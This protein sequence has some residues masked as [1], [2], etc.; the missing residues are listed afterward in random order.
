MP[1]SSILGKAWT[2]DQVRKIN[3]RFK[4]NNVLD[5]GVG[6]GTYIDNYKSIVSD[7]IWTGI[8]VWEPYIKQYDLK[9][10]YN[11]II[12]QDVRKVDYNNLGKFDIVFAG[13][14]LEHMTK[15]EAIVVVDNLLKIS[16]SLFISIPIVHMPQGEWAGNPYEE[17][18]KDDWSDDEVKQTFGQYIVTSGSFEEI[19]VYLLS[20]DNEF[21]QQFGNTTRIP[22]IIHFIY[23]GYTDF[24][25][26]H[27]AS[28]KSAITVHKPKKVYIYNSIEPTNNKYWNDIVKHV[29]VVKVT[30]PEEFNNI[31]LEKFQYKADIFRLQKLIEMGGIYMDIDVIS[32]K[33]F[34]DLLHESLVLGVESADNPN[35]IDLN[36]IKSI[37]NAVILAE[38]NHPFL[39]EWLKQTG[40]NLE[41]K[42]WAYHAVNL[43]LELTKQQDWHYQLLPRKSFMPFDFRDEFIF[44]NDKNQLEKINDSYTMHLWETIWWDKLNNIDNNSLLH[45]IIKP[46][47][48]KKLKIAIYTICKNEEEFV[49]RWAK[50]NTEADIRLVCDTGSTDNTVKK[51]KKHKVNVVP[52][53]VSPWRFDT[54]RNTALNLLPADIDVCIWQDL[55]EELLPGWRQAIESNWQNN[56]TTANHRYR[57]NDGNWQWHNKIHA[58]HGCIW[59]GAVHESLKW[60]V[61][62]SDIWIE[63]FYLDEHQNT[64]KPRSSYLPLLL[65][66]IEEGDT[67]WRTFF[68]LSNEYGA[69]FEKNLENKLKAYE[70]CNEGD[71]VK[72]YIARA[73]GN[74]Y[75]HHN[76]NDLAKTWYELSLG[77]SKERETYYSLAKFYNTIQDHTMCFINAE[78]G[79]RVT[80]RRNGFTYDA[81]A[82]GYILYDYAAMSAYYIGLKEKAVEY[83]RIAVELNPYDERLKKNLAFYEELVSIPFPEVI[84]IETNS[85]CNRT[86]HACLRNSHPDREKVSSWF[87][88]KLMPMEQIKLIF[89]QAKYMGFKKDIGLS[90]F[91][92]PLSDPR[93][94][95]IL[96]LAKSY[97]FR[98]IF[99]HSNGDL[100]TKELAEKIDGLVNWITFSVYAEGP[101]KTKREQEIKSYF[102][103]TNV[104]FTVGKL[105]L[106]HYGP[107]EELDE[108]IKSV[109]DLSCPEPQ[110]RMVINHKGQMEFCCE[111]IGGNFD[112][113]S[114]SEN[115]SL[116]DLWNNVDFQNK[117]KQLMRKGGRRGLKHCENCPRP[118]EMLF[119]AK[120]IKVIKH[121]KS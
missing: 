40:D 83:G 59:K 94:V 43:P 57:H 13:D 103:K 82:W 89:D 47:S 54:A 39:V 74:H 81:V 3:K 118:K 41:N 23:F 44:S 73:I 35:T 99:F 24:L 62:E 55:D 60:L 90:H 52:I 98:N 32:L 28:I 76:Q 21:V 86:C 11:H 48:L 107:T 88:N 51:L 53:T 87:E 64:S 69:D 5:I 18:V 20:N 46:H 114:V 26:I 15:E 120:N 58:R 49:D 66:K 104:R 96:K 30:P 70:N 78:N 31:K 80:E 6:M 14:V 19:G 101:A 71:I 116:Y 17:H 10:K 112:L 102:S 56:T 29:E 63:E 37:S 61:P 8:E 36:E 38:K 84:E 85:N 117:V 93:I 27:Y 16:K 72:A 95:D 50:T 105:G 79:I 91:N 121:E 111:D 22:N 33:P 45:D 108:V 67:Y 65:K 77:H 109:I 1:S 75:L 2:G 68:F 4:V 97:N 7:A 12:N 100:L 115:N 106:T 119:T 34:N 110:H 25:P 113:G 92:E 42:P 9:N